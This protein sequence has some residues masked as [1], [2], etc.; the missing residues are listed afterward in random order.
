VATLVDTQLNAGRYSTVVN[1]THATNG[2][3]LYRLAIDTLVVERVMA[4]L[5]TNLS[6]LIISTPL[7]NTDGSGKFSLKI[8]A[9]GFGVPLI[10]TSSA[11]DIVDT[12]YI[13]PSIQFVFFKQGYSTLIQSAV[14]DTSIDLSREFT[15]TR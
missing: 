11:G 8:R 10:Q 7:A 3:Y 2:L 5:N 14:I 4:L 9:L 6:E 13:S 1:V 12:L 15:I